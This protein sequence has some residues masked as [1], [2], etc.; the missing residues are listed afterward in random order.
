M[1]EQDMYKVYFL[2]IFILIVGSIV[3]PMNSDRSSL[4]PF[5]ENQGYKDVSISGYSFFG[6]G[7]NDFYR[8][9]FSAINPSGNKIEGIV[10]EGLFF[11]AKTIRLY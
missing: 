4:I 2:S 3:I 11:K 1:S 6:C 9:K 10:C 8:N 5:L 7:N